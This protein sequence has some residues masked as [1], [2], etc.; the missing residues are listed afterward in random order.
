MGGGG[1]GDLKLSSIKTINQLLHP[2]EDTHE[3]PSSSS[4]SSRVPSDK[5]TKVQNAKVHVLIFG[6]LWCYPSY[7]T[8]WHAQQLFGVLKTD[9]AIQNEFGGQVQLHLIDSEEERDYCDQHDI[10][11]GSSVLIVTTEGGRSSSSSAS[12][13]G[14]GSGENLLFK[15]QDWPLND[16]LIGPFN[17]AALKKIIRTAVGAIMAGKKNVSVNIV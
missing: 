7:A 15:R 9:K 1:G 4:S 5:D 12:G 8:L 10:M 14:G 3:I 2:D 16:R 11:V 13:G 17:K 6:C